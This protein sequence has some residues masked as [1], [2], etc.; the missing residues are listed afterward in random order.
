MFS[1]SVSATAIQGHLCFRTIGIM[2]LSGHKKG[3]CSI[4][5]RTNKIFKR[6]AVLKPLPS[7]CGLF[8]LLITG[9]QSTKM[10]SRAVCIIFSRCTHGAPVAPRSLCLAWVI[11]KENKQLADGISFHHS[12]QRASCLNRLVAE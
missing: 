6:G 10:S 1:G 9:P 5:M 12:F 2:S 7:C 8:F 4:M 3:K 11:L